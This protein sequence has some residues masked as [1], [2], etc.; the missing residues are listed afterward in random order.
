MREH[1]QGTWSQARGP[2]KHHGGRVCQRMSLAHCSLRNY[3]LLTVSGQD[4]LHLLL[5]C[6]R[7]VGFRAPT[8]QCW[9]ED[10]GCGEPVVMEEDRYNLGVWR[11]G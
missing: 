1:G 2:P 4:L 3:P 11:G 5:A 10:C 9:G 8:E 6:W 7:W